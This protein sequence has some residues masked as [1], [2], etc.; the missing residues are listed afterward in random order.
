R[1]DVVDKPSQRNYLGLIHL[2][3]SLGREDAVD[4][5][6]ERLVAAGY[7][8]LNGPRIPGD[9]YSAA[10]VLG[11]DEIQIELTVY[12]W[13]VILRDQCLTD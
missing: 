2:A 7:L 4:E 13:Q 9:G 8:L 10:W 11:F 1:D 12:C 6:T 3:F 5:F